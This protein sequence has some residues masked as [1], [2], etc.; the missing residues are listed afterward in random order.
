MR[1][2][3]DLLLIATSKRQLTTMLLELIEAVGKVG[4]VVHAGKSKVLT[5]G[6]VACQDSAINVG[7]HTFEILEKSKATVH[8]GWALSFS[9]TRDAELHN[10][11]NKAW[12]KFMSLKSELCCKRYS[13]RSPLKLFDAVIAPTIFYACGSWTMTSSREML[14]LTTQTKILRKIL[15]LG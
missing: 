14:L 10:R 9:S 2:A 5:N 11:I 15:G 7:E 8:L 4:L 12:W 6:L 13:L 3:D 1:F